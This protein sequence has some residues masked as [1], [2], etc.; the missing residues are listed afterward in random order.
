MSGLAFR[1]F[2]NRNELHSSFI[3]HATQ[4]LYE[5]NPNHF[6]YSRFECTVISPSFATDIT[7]RSEGLD[8]EMMIFIHKDERSFIDIPRFRGQWSLFFKYASANYY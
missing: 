7:Q 1:R 5:R 3:E 2:D 6:E 8:I 4:T